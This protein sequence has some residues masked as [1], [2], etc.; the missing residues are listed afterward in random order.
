MTRIPNSLV[1][2]IEQIF[3]RFG[4]GMRAKLITI[5]VAIKVIPLVV[6]ALLAWQQARLLGEELRQR[7]E[8]LT[9]TATCA[10]GQASEIA[11]ADAVEALETRAREDIERMTTDT[12]RRVADFL[13]ARDGDILL[14]A[15]LQ[16]DAGIYGQ[17]IESKR[18]R[19]IRQGTWRLSDDETSWVDVSGN[20]PSED[21]RATIAENEANFHY[22]APDSFDYEN[23]PLYLEMA[24]VDPQ[25]RELVKAVSSPR[26]DARLKD[27]SQRHNTYARAES[28]F[29][30]LLR[31]KPGDIFVSDVI[32]SYVRSRVIGAYTPAGAARAGEDFAPEKSAYAGKEN[33]VGKRFQGIVRWATPVERNGKIIGYVTLAL[34]HDHLMRFTDHQTPAAERYTKIPDAG[35]GNY[36]FIWD[37]KGRSIVHPRHF[38]ITGYNPETGD[39]EVPWLEASVY[40][41][42]QASGKSYAEFIP[43]APTFHEQT[44]AKKPARPLTEQGLVGLDCRYLNFAAQCTGWFN[45]TQ[46]GG[47]GSFLIS[48]SGLRKLT[49]AAAIPYYTGQYGASPRGFGFVTIGAEIADFQQPATATK[50]TLDT[51]FEQSANALEKMQAEARDAIARNLRG[52]TYSLIASTCLM[53]IIVVFIAIGMAS[54]FTRSI[55]SL[56]AGI[57]RFR[58]GERHFRFHAPIKDELG[59]LADSFDEM[60]DSLV[61]SVKDPLTIV[62]TQLNVRYMNDAG[63][64]L[65]GTANLQEILGEPY[66][67]HSI[68]P[69]DSP[70]CPITA[71]QQGRAPEVFF[72]EPNGRYYR[73]TA[74]HLTDRKS[75]EHIGYIVVAADCTT[76]I[77]EQQEHEKQRAMLH[78]IFTASPDLMWFKDREGK[79]LAT[80]PRFDGLAFHERKRGVNSAGA[81]PPQSAGNDDVDALD[82]IVVEGRMQLATE[83][84]LL[85]ADGHAEVADVVRTPVFSSSGEY[86]GILGVARDVSRRVEIERELRD[87][88][89][90]FETAAAQANKANEA[91][92]AFLA[93]MSHEIRTPLGAIIGMT[94][95]IK[96]KLSDPRKGVGH[97]DAHVRQIEVSSQHLLALLNDILDISKIEAGKIEL[98]EDILDLPKLLENV[99]SI[100][101]PRSEEKN[102]HFDV[103]AGK[104]EPALYICDALRLRQALINFLGNAVKF[105][106]ASG[107]VGLAVE[108][109]ERKDGK[110]RIKF[111]IS[112]TGIGIPEPAL[113]KLFE[114][115]EQAHAGIAQQYGGTGLGMSINRRIV[116][117][118]GSTIEVQ[119]AENKGSTFSFAIWLPEA[120]EAEQAAAAPREREASLAGKRALLVD[121][122]AINRLIVVELLADTGLQIEEA[123]DGQQCIDAFAASVPGYFDII[124]MDAQMPNVD[125]YEATRAI[126]ALERS[127]ARTVPIVTMTAN[128]FKEDIEK[129]MDS[130][131]NAHI[132]KPLEL[133]KLNEVLVRYLG[134][135]I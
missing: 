64:L 112:D 100:I 56:I 15:M 73:G 91:K 96:R 48:W 109:L 87:T 120:Q 98:S 119:S 105:T 6:L 77:T 72:Y 16:P 70:S 3:A 21:I 60:A 43:M 114:P 126:R 40:D 78:T 11:I 101:A 88:Q 58:F 9:G 74:N 51:L 45:L 13:Y 18:G 66:A 30:D 24:F 127:D 123:E 67:L 17:F 36:A 93:L 63:L 132:A 111:A 90:A 19:L 115:F 130:G 54:V 52:T 89:M 118:M 103:R 83:E 86:Q 8:Q 4:L 39:P 81:A 22:R 110:S 122:V 44:N 47:S 33:P 106:P 92:S 133:D 124:F 49:T 125:G 35:E 46:N 79:Y 41:A 29:P 69:Q 10:L 62:D 12:A 128:A 53:V 135:G 99:V 27:V 84:T 59:T 50:A 76:I 34:D 1:H 97:I 37:H 7:T 134:G 75:G 121:D 31:L 94:N 14:A 26:M 102:I 129:A 95:I 116:E 28:Y 32:G 2:R 82:A 55:I 57:S 38:S 42:W 25:G 85:F 20:A 107:T 68:Y 117:M 113:A 61:E 23:R 131:M 108:Q 71:L 104:I 5:F 80:N 65:I